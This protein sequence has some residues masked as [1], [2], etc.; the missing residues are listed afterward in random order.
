METITADLRQPLCELL[1]SIAD[2]KFLLG[3]RNADW[4]G[5]APILEEDIAFSSMAQ[6]EIS[7]AG[8][9]FQFIAGV[10][11]DTTA[12]RLAFGRSPADYRCAAIVEVGDDFDWAV[13]IVR[14]FFCDHFDNLRLARLAA[15]NHRPLAALAARL[16]AEEAMHVTHADSWIR[17]LGRGGQDARERMQ[18]A[19][20]KL[21]PLATSLLEPT[22]GVTAL[23]AAGLYPKAAGDMFAYWAGNLSGVVADAHLRL[24]LTPPPAEY[25]GGRR[26]RHTA[27]FAAVLAEL[28]EVSAVE[29]EASW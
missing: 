8:A 14:Q 27:E 13:A 5:L 19:F 6:D 28:T 21:A 20:D 1:L 16:R 25:V 7:H 29:P 2:D 23:E 9:L 26:G 11:G 3:H 24:E 15:S 18:A 10:R 12:D 4:T 17:R 22:D